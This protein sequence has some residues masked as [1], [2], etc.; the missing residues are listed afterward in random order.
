MFLTPVQF[1]IL[2]KLFSVKKQA[3]K[4]KWILWVQAQI[5]K[6]S[7]TFFF[8]LN[9]GK[10]YFV[11]YLKMNIPFSCQQ[12]V[13]AICMS[14]CI[15]SFPLVVVFSLRLWEDCSLSHQDGSTSACCTHTHKQTHTRTHI[16][17]EAAEQTY[18]CCQCC[19]VRTHHESSSRFTSHLMR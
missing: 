5:S 15:R 13:C 10:Y 2:Q 14:V 11:S 1:F 9:V 7:T 16:H 6:I 18:I 19:G 8:F 4:R 17:F 3:N 12:W